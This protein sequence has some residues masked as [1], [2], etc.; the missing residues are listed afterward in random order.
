[1]QV[2]HVWHANHAHFDRLHV[3]CLRKYAIAH[4]VEHA[5]SAVLHMSLVMGHILQA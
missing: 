5:L 2:E 4:L 3:F 1:M